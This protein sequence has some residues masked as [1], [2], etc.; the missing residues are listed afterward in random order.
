MAPPVGRSLRAAR[1][2]TA[3][4][5]ARHSELDT[6]SLNERVTA[7][8]P[9]MTSA[10]PWRARPTF[11]RRPRVEAVF[12]F[13]I[14][15]AMI[16]SYRTFRHR[17]VRVVTLHHPRHVPGRQSIG[18]LHPLL[19]SFSNNVLSFYRLRR[20]RGRS[21]IASARSASLSMFPTIPRRRFWRRFSRPEIGCTAVPEALPRPPLRLARM[22]DHSQPSCLIT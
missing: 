20:A 19:I 8:D 22:T 10:A 3:R 14:G 13:S 6:T 7:A 21:F 15:T 2:G 18:A 17:A 4:A 12:P 5:S 11:R 16:V 1:R 9:V